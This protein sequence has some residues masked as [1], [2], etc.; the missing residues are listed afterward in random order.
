MLVVE[1]HDDAVVPR[2]RGEVGHGAGA[3]L[4]VLAGDLRLGRALHGQGQAP[5][6]WRR[7]RGQ[8]ASPLPRCP[9]PAPAG[10]PLTFPGILGDNGEGGRLVD[11]AMAQAWSVGADVAAVDGVHVELQG[12]P[13]GWW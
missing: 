2:R 11:H 12:A 10:A 8:R 3:V 13:W 6:G 7:G 5:C 1:A 4:V 9:S